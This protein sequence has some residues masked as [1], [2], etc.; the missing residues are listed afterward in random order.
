[1][2]LLI[3][4]SRKKGGGNGGYPMMLVCGFSERKEKVAT[5]YSIFQ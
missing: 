5:E 2:L 3:P 1:M 4:L